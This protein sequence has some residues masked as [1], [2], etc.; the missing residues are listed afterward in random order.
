MTVLNANLRSAELTAQVKWQ[1]RLCIDGC[2]S[3]L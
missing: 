3:Y 2:L 1:Q